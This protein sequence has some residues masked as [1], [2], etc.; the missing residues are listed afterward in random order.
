MTGP[1]RPE[2]VTDEVTV[3]WRKLNLFGNLGR[4][5]YTSVVTWWLLFVLAIVTLLAIFSGF[6]FPSGVAG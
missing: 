1:P 4:H 2:Q 3:N 5:W 6:V